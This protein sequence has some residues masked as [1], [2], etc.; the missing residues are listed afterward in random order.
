MDKQR[1]IL[2]IVLSAAILF[3]WSILFPVKPPPP[4]SNTNSN[5]SATEQKTGPTPASSETPAGSQDKQP[6]PAAGLENLS[7][8][9]QPRKI[10]VSTPLYDVLLDNHGAVA[11]SWIIK[12]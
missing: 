12:K 3:G 4:Q 6:A 11:T 2:A 7:E 5:S 1:F 9:I 10:K 8:N